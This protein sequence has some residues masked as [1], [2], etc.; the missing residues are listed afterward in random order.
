[1]FLLVYFEFGFE[2]YSGC[3]DISCEHLQICFDMF[4]HLEFE[5]LN[6]SHGSIWGLG[7]YDIFPQTPH[8]VTMEK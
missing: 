8:D 7:P 3:E 1:L 4:C 2:N 5:I 6:L